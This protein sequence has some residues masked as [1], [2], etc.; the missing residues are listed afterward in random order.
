MTVAGWARAARP[1]F[2]VVTLVAAVLGVAL[3]QACGSAWDPWGAVATVVLAMTLH[4]AANL[5]NDYGDA[6]GGS[7]AINTARIGPF[8][9]GSR[10]VQDGRA[11]AAQMR[12]AAQMLAIVAVGGG[13][14]LAARSGPGLLA[15]GLAGCL[16]GWAYSSPRVALM[17]RGLGEA[18][19][20]LAW[21]LVVIGADYVQRHRFDAIAALGGVSPALLIAAVLW[22][23][24]FPDRQADAAAGKRTAVVRLGPVRA[25]W[26]HLALVL[27]AYAWVASW[28]WWQWL[29]T[30]AWWA[31][32]SLPLNLVAAAVLL[33]PARN[34]GA[35]LRL[36]IVLTLAAAVVHSLLLT[37]AFLAVVSL[38]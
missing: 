15:V 32:G 13:V 3:S 4:A 38:R 29:P 26:L 9:G 2:L 18:A 36:A 35:A 23:A 10:T 14:W 11:T 24:E 6:V 17:S 37:G 34:G 27:A 8:T 7:D 25:A 30:S 16:L 12:D 1:G 19:V 5:Y 20:A 22:V 33:R 28:W 31:L 21:W